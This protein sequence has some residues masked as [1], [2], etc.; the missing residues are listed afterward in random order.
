[1]KRK[2][3]KIAALW[4]ALIALAVVYTDRNSETWV[5]DVSSIPWILETEADATEAQR[6]ADEALE[7][8]RAVAYARRDAGLW[9]KPNQYGGDLMSLPARTEEE[10]GLNL[11]WGEYEAV[12][13]YTAGEPMTLRT[14]SAGRQ[15]FIENGELTLPAAPQ[16][17][18]ATLR[19]TLTDAT[20][21]VMLACDVPENAKVWTVTVRRVCQ[22]VVS[23]D[24]LVFAAIAGG[25]LTWLLVLSWDERR[26]GAK[27]RRD[28]IILL[29]AVLFASAPALIFGL[30]D[31]HDVQFH[32]NRI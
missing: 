16:G 3:L 13:R 23:P 6:E 7:Q 26:E 22:R 32:L 2:A 25:V 27:R 15:L 28:A 1:M 21:G 19:F 14:V 8:E 9:G 11:M 29:C 10:P 31:G 12:V 20:E 4:L 30:T 18:E 5:Y 17:A 24:L